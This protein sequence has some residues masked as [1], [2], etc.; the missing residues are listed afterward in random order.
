MEGNL[1]ATLEYENA[2]ELDSD[3]EAELATTSA[4]K[5][6]KRSVR[7]RSEIWDHFTRRESGEEGGYCKYC[8]K[9]TFIKGATTNLFCHLKSFHLSIFQK[10]NY[11]KSK[12]QNIQEAGSFISDPNVKH[13]KQGGLV[14]TVSVKL[15]KELDD[16]GTVCVDT[17]FH[18][19]S[20]VL[21]IVKQCLD[22]GVT[23][24]ISQFAVV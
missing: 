2:L 12:R 16:L 4:N 15:R 7:R 23:I 11:A 19:N 24:I 1:D 13:L 20:N 21:P 6:V 17:C 22:S 10:T 9:T 14:F 3:D 8:K 5:A 18:I